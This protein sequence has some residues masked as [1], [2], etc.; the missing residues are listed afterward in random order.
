M[1]HETFARMGGK[2]RA[3]KLTAK[4]RTESARKAANA[5]WKRKKGN[6]KKAAAAKKPR[7]RK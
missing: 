7:A 4:Q 2:A 6:P 5:R 1:D 3:R